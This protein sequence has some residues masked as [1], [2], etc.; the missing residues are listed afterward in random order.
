MPFDDQNDILVAKDDYFIT[1]QTLKFNIR[2]DGRQYLKL[3]LPGQDGLR[4]LC[5]LKFYDNANKVNDYL[6]NDSN[7]EYCLSN[8]QFP[9]IN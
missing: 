3:A 4:G 1:F 8:N 7:K 5:G 6:V 2:Y 9:I